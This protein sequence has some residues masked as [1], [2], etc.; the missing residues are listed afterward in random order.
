[1]SHLFEPFTLRGVTL[2][3]R[4]GISPMC[5]YS[6]QD[7]FANDW[8]KIHLGARA[9][10][11]AG[12]IITEAAAVEPRGRITPHCLGIWSDA[13]ADALAET[14]AFCK[15]HGATMG[16]QLAHAGR[17]ASSKRPWDGGGDAPNAQGGWDTIGPSA[18]R[19]SEAY[20][21]PRE[22]RVDEIKAVEQAFVDVARSL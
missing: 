1:M 21:Q 4:V 11:G 12:L 20:R 19:F 9:T 14:V 17:K 8:H 22:M 6:A 2:R 13:H 5:Q 3:N 16:I 15:A 7:G 10:G 18:L